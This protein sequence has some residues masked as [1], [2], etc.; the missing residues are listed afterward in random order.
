MKYILKKTTKN[1]VHSFKNN[2]EWLAKHPYEALIFSK[3]QSIWNELSKSYLGTF[4]NLVY[5]KLPNE[6]EILKTLEKI[7]RRIKIWTG[8]K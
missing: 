3:T 2:N 4:S 1:D 7:A 5:G 6:N 8:L